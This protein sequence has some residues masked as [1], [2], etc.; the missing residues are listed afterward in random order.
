LELMSFCDFVV[1]DPAATFGLPEI[2]LAFFPP[3]ACYQMPRLSGLQNA[4]YAILSGEKLSADRAAAM[5]LVQKVLPKEEWGTLDALFNG[6]SVPALRAAKEALLQGAG[7][8]R[9][10]ALESLKKLF[11]DR[12]Y[13]LEDVQEGIRSFEEK[14]NP[15]WRHR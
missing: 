15:V 2:K 14:R 13:R 3:L 8:H 7:A 4:A 11:V 6:L 12:L 5:G 9:R 1:A 10:D